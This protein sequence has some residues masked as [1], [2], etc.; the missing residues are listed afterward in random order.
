MS[1]QFIVSHVSGAI[2]PDGRAADTWSMAL[3]SRQRR[4]IGRELRD[5]VFRLCTAGGGFVGLIWGL[6]HPSKPQRV[7]PA[8]CSAHAAHPVAQCMHSIDIAGPIGAVLIPF[9]IG[10][11]VGA[12]VGLLV[13]SMIR[14]GRTPQLGG[15]SS[16]GR[17]IRAR[18]AG[19]CERCGCSVVPGDRIRH[20]PGHVFCASCGER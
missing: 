10:L 1:C 6:H 3:S 8:Q 12:L 17:W 9:C 16:A 14:L 20:R 7:N 5:I 4:L 19:R 11:L 18:Y 13:V 2:Q 15:Q